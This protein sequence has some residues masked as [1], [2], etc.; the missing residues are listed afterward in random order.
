MKICPVWTELFHVDRHDEANNCSSQICDHAWKLFLFYGGMLLSTN[1]SG[2][3]G[4]GKRQGR[5]HCNIMLII[6]KVV[7][8]RGRQLE[9]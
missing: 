1:V 3:T 9:A 4:H 7:K 5:Q 6:K 8:G 2:A